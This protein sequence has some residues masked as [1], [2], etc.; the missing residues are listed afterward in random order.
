MTLRSTFS[1]AG[2][3]VGIALALATACS[4]ASADSPGSSATGAGSAGASQDGG[5]TAGAAG[6]TGQPH[7][8][9]GAAGGAQ[10]VVTTDSGVNVVVGPDGGS[11]TDY[12]PSCEEQQ[13]TA[14]EQCVEGPQGT[15]CVH[16]CPG[17]PCPRPDMESF[18]DRNGGVICI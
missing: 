6:S 14:E 10:L 5:S 17:Q 9:G 3:V 18:C 4:A 13:C 2:F 16:P 1:R 8:I 11:Y 15:Y 12:H 7:L